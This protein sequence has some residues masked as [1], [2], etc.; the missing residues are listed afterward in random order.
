MLAACRQ[1]YG[2]HDC[3]CER[4]DIEMQAPLKGP[5]AMVGGKTLGVLGGMGPL[6]GASFAYRLAQLTP[7]RNDQEH[8]PV[9]LRNDPRIPDRSASR[10]GGGTDPLPAMLEGMQFLARSG[11]DCIAIPCN[12][13]HLWFDALQAEVAVPVMH[14][15]ESVVED[16]R[17]QGIHG[18]KIGI[19]GTAATLELG[20]YQRYLIQAGYE[21]LV[22]SQTEILDC[23]IPAINAVKGNRIDAA[24]FPAS[25]GIAALERRGAQAVVLGCTELP[26]A[27]PHHRRAEF[28][29]ALTDSIDALAFS[30]LERFN[31]S[32]A[33][34]LAV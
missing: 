8:I 14:I 29:P 11:V 4:T 23:C 24:F 22:P 18:G 27:V 28:G 6:A 13:A 17:R 3:A 5:A 25:L 12:T 33:V 2:T 7:A 34:A 19:M 21:P 30:V 15:V 31:A 10:L 26:L 32:E 20:L 1:P 16:L 9:L